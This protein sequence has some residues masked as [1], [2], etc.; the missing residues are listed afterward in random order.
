MPSPSLPKAKIFAILFTLTATLLLGSEDLSSSSVKTP[1]WAAT[2]ARFSGTEEIFRSPNWVGLRVNERLIVGDSLRTGPNSTLVLRFNDKSVLELAAN[3]EA[4]IEYF[5]PKTGEALIG[6]GAG[7]IRAEVIR[8]QNN[9]TRFKIRTGAIV[10]GVRGTQFMLAHQENRDYGMDAIAVLNG[11]VEVRDAATNRVITQMYRDQVLTVS[12]RDV[13][14]GNIFPA[15]AITPSMWDLRVSDNSGVTRFGDHRIRVAQGI[16]LPSNSRKWRFRIEGARKKK[17]VAGVLATQFTPT[18]MK[19]SSLRAVTEIA[20]ALNVPVV[21]PDTLPTTALTA[22]AAPTPAPNI[23]AVRDKSVLAA[24]TAPSSGALLTNLRLYGGYD[25]VYSAD[26]ERNPDQTITYSPATMPMPTTAV[27]SDTLNEDTS[28]MLHEGGWELTGGGGTVTPGPLP[29]INQ[30]IADAT[31]LPMMT[32]GAS[33]IPY[34]TPLPSPTMS[35]TMSP[36]PEMMGMP[37]AG[38]G[39]GPM[40]QPAGQWDP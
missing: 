13:E 38:G 16:F 21:R 6:L 35:P 9:E 33:P 31:P 1:V 40:M 18:K 4:V 12:S 22:R 15:A 26:L 19:Q 28:E 2:V 27:S 20:S 7:R 5:E 3:S 30:P 37:P 17:L 10:A 24:I 14:R 29:P 23:V 34:L 39:G 11:V 32:P 36:M 8:R 25:P